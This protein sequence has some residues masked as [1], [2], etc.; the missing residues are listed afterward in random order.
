MSYRLLSE[1]NHLARKTHRCTWCGELIDKGESYTHERSVYDG[2]MQ[3]QH[4]HPECLS[5]MRDEASVDGG[6]VE[7]I[8]GEQSRPEQKP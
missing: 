1:K 6:V 7:W 4:W 2:Y 8:T 3:S 5:A